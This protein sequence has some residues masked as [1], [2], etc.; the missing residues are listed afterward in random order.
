MRGGGGGPWGAHPVEETLSRRDASQV[1][2]RLTQILRPYRGRIAVAVLLL[3]GQTSCLLAGPA[4]VRYGID[5]GLRAG[6]GGAL[7][8]AAVLYLG[9]A[10]LGLGFGRAVII[11][12]SRVG[13]TF[14][15]DLRSNVFRHLMSL[16]MDFFEKEKTGKLVAR[17]TSDIEALQELV[18]MGLVMFVQNAMI[19]VGAILVIFLLSWKLA[20]VTLI[21]VPPVVIAS[22]WFR[23][24][25]N[26]AYL[27]V[28]DRI[29][30]NLS[31][32]QEGLAGVRVVQA[33]AR[34]RAFTRR[35]RETNEA[36]LVVTVLQLRRRPGLWRSRS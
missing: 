24:A 35:F 7:N 29:G 19:F 36:V 28:R 11:M 18:Q 2:R 21:V 6:D 5:H 9:A 26:K 10:V 27:L 8:R 25:S 1:L 4:L 33:F 12:V 13:E 15:R 30:Q 22:R 31:T 14:L 32:L 16:G 17:M 23:R 34:E 3:I 20:V